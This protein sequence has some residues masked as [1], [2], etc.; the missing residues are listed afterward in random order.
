LE[1]ASINNA[2]SLFRLS[3]FKYEDKLIFPESNNSPEINKL[4]DL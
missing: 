4:L 2:T 3:I 1:N